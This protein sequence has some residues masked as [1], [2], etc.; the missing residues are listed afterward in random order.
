[1][2]KK[3]LI[4]C[5]LIVVVMSLGVVNSATGEKKTEQQV[6]HQ[7]EQL[8][9]IKRY[10]SRQRQE[11]EALYQ[12]RLT[13][14][15]LRAEAK[16]RLLEVA[17][18]AVYSS[19]AAQAEVAKKVLHIDNYGYIVPWYLKAKTERM[20]QLKGDYISY[21]DFKNE[22]EKSTKRFA[23]AQSRIAERKSNILASLESAV[24]ILERQK[25]YALTVRLAELE[26][27]LK[28]NVLAPKPR[29]THGV[30]TGI[31]YSEEKASAVIDGKIVHHGDTIHSVRVIKIHTDKVEFEKNGERWNQ[32][33]R[34]KLK[35]YWE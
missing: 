31:V 2:E 1:M 26:K 15:R 14:V 24:I 32:K 8:E 28:E 20:L 22:I 21:R 3:S 4:V 17:D 35:V 16:I 13:D 27:R 19:L 11:I 12:G 7:K 33:V 34:E 29:A 5:V 9:E 30:V 10:I 18:K 25:K 23:V 6:K